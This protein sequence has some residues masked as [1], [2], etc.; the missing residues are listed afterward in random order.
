MAGNS[1]LDNNNKVGYI[2]WQG[3]SK[4]I[5]EYSCNFSGIIEWWRFLIYWFIRFWTPTSHEKNRKVNIP[6]GTVCYVQIKWLFMFT[7]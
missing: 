3:A 2:K 1:Q 6:K 5:S 7:R 4:E